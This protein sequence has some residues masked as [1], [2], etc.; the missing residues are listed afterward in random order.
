MTAKQMNLHE[1]EGGF[2]PI[3]VAIVIV[4]IIIGIIG[5]I[6]GGDSGEQQK[7]PPV[8]GVVGL[9]G[10][11]ISTTDAGYSLSFYVGKKYTNQEVKVYLN[12][13]ALL[14]VTQDYQ[15]SSDTQTYYKSYLPSL[16]NGSNDVKIIV[17]NKEPGEDPV[18]VASKEFKINL[19]ATIQPTISIKGATQTDNGWQIKDVKD[20]NYKLTIDTTPKDSKNSGAASLTINGES[21]PVSSSRGQ[22]DYTIKALKDGDSTF[23]ITAKNEIGEITDTLTITKISAAE[24]AANAAFADALIEAQ[25]ACAQYAE[26]TL[27]VKDVNI[28]YTQSSIRKRND[29]GTVLIKANIA[30]DKGWFKS[31]IPL[32]IMECTTDSTGTKVINFLH[33]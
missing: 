15:H 26:L 3:I 6:F 8:I 13:S 19:K 9:S 4:V 18:T 23:T 17:N 21:V 28:S 5:A 20:D 33:Y 7:T 32:G 2:V 29:D 31:D 24:Q 1:R 25:A 14:S 11:S 16:Q 22:F 12:G 27:N 10:S 30:E